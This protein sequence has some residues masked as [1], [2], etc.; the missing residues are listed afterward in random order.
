MKATPAT[1]NIA[2]II[3]LNLSTGEIAGTRII[4]SRDDQEKA[5]LEL[6]RAITK[7]ARR[8]WL[9]RLFQRNYK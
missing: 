9:R 4:T 6:A 7:Q 8:G 2:I 3:E 5:A 1:G